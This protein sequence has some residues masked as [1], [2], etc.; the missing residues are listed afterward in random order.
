MRKV[1]SLGRISFKNQTFA[2]GRAFIGEPV[3]LRPTAIDGCY[4]VIYCLAK[5]AELDL[6]EAP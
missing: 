3:A 5:I 1:Q 2:V 6:N 4:D